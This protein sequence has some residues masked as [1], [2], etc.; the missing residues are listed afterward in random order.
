MTG[1]VIQS[2]HPNKQEKITLSKKA[3]ITY[4]KVHYR[5]R[6]ERK[7]YINIISPDIFLPQDCR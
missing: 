4:E 1:A 3:G 5:A 2:P 6:A 7:I